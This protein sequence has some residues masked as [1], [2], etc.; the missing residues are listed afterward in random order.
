ME[1]KEL[2]EY[3]NNIIDSIRRDKNLNIKEF[4]QNHIK[5][6][7]E[8][9]EKIEFLENEETIHDFFSNFNCEFYYKKKKT[10]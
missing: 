3:C 8:T 1:K 10:V 6:L 9:D 4:S 5:R 2:L 7:Y